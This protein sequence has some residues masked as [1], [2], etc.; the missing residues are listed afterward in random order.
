MH[1][2]DDQVGE[3]ISQRPEH[4]KRLDDPHSDKENIDENSVFLILLTFQDLFL[5]I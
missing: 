1:L 4:H 3:K 2:V 5:E